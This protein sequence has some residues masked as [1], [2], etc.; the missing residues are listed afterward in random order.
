[1]RR[2]PTQAPPE[3]ASSHKSV[4]NPRVRCCRLADFCDNSVVATVAG[5]P[6]TFVPLA[7]VVAM[8]GQLSPRPP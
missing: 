1:M 4:R 7:A 8:Q 6:S 5:Y 2:F 3:Y